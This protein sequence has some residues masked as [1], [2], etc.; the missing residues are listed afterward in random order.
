MAAPPQEKGPLIPEVD[1]D[2]E[3]ARIPPLMSE[4]RKKAF[5]VFLRFL[6]LALIW[7]LSFM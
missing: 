6:I 2:A 1:E 3:L 7:I 4:K 5:D